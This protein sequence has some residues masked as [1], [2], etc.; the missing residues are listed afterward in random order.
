[1]SVE[2]AYNYGRRYAA[3][4][5]AQAV[6]DIPGTAPSPVVSLTSAE[7]RALPI[8]LQKS[9]NAARR[10]AVPW[11]GEDYGDSAGIDTKGFSWGDVGSGLKG[12][13]KDYSASMR[14]GDRMQAQA[15]AGTGFFKRYLGGALGAGR[16][17]SRR[18][19]PHLDTLINEPGII[20]GMDVAGDW[21]G[22]KTDQ[23]FSGFDAENEDGS[24]KGSLV[25]SLA[26]G[27]D[28][29]SRWGRG[30]S[31]SVG[32]WFSDVGKIGK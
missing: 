14:Y 8:D 28:A 19:S 12:L 6:P 27:G 24:R 21:I 5:A 31:K 9:R 17:F 2:T 11:R 10:D 25:D 1:M 20:R 15:P 23:A 3:V 4:K 30:V 13:A 16:E 29:V 22:K 18:I 7:H 32:N 26:D